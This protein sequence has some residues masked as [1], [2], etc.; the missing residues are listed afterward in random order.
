[1][2]KEDAKVVADSYKSNMFDFT[3]N[4]YK[5]ICRKAMLNDE[6]TKI[7]EMRIKGYSIIKMALELNMSERTI[8]RRI[9]ELKRKITK[10]L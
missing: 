4:E 10:I 6:L 5:E 9:K 3:E 8:N 7:L 1:M 2:G